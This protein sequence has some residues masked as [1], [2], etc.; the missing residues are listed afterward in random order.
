MARHYLTGNEI[1]FF[2]RHPIQIFAGA[3]VS[4]SAA[5]RMLS[6]PLRK[7]TTIEESYSESNFW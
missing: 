3:S 4:L 6:V 7:A 5:F 1:D 2:K